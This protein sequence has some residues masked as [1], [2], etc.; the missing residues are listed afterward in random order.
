MTKS[1]NLYLA[2]GV[3]EGVGFWVVNFTEEDNILNSLCRKLLECYRKELFGLEGAKEV[4]D[5]IN[6][7]LD[8]LCLDSN[9]EKY[10]LDNYN[11]GYSSEIPINLIEDIYDLWAYN[12]SNKILWKKYIGLL[13]LRKKIKKNN[14]YINIGLKGDTYE[15]ATKLDEL[16]SFRQVNLKFRQDK[17]NDLMW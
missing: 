9:Y 6:T 3:S 16:L 12:Y 8:L 1:V 15:F 14:N 10:K 5:A 17:S 7:T 13:N 11:T 4:K 2:S